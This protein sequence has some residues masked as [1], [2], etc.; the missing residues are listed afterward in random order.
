MNAPGPRAVTLEVL[1]DWLFLLEA[2]KNSAE[3]LDPL[4]C[5]ALVRRLPQ[6]PP[7]PYGQPIPGEGRGLITKHY[8]VFAFYS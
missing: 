4:S 3:H 1:H 5:M 2:T 7:W 6:Q 8:V